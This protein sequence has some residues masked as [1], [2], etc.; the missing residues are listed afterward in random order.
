MRDLV[1]LVGSGLRHVGPTRPPGGP[2]DDALLAK[3]RG[4]DLTGY[5]DAHLRSALAAATTTGGP[6]DSLA[7]VHA[8]VNEA[9]GRR[10]GAWRILRTDPD[11]GPTATYQ[12][13]AR[14]VVE[15]AP[16]RTQIG[17]YTDEGFVDSPRF[18]ASLQ[19]LMD[20]MGLDPDERTVV[21]TIVY[22]FEKSK[23][24]Y[25]S[26][27]MLSSEFYR[28]VEALSPQGDLAFRVT[29]EQLMAGLLLYRG[30]IVEMNAGEGKTVAGAFPATMH[31]LM[32]RPVH[33]ITAN[34]YL[35]SRDAEWLAPVYES[36][37]LTVGAVLGHMSDEERRKTYQAQIV[38]GTLRE[39]GFDFLRDNLRLSPDEMV[40]R[41]L[42]VAIVDE[43]D[44]A[45][46]D[47]ARTPLIISGKPRVSRR[48]VRRAN[49]AVCELIGRQAELVSDLETKLRQSRPTAG[50]D[51]TL[52]ARLVLA[53]PES[54]ELVRWL[55]ADRALRRRVRVI[56]ASC[57][58]DG[59]APSIEAGLYYTVDPRRETVTLTDMGQALIE[60]HLGPTLDLSPSEPQLGRPEPEQD[61]MSLRERRR[62]ADKLSRQI[63]RRSNLMN[64]VHQ[65]LRAHLLL[66]R[67]VD[68]IVIDGE[69]VLIDAVTGR[70]RL[71]SMF[72][73]GLHTAL[74]AKEGLPL[75]P[76][77]E[78][79]AQVSIQGYAK[80]YR[81]LSG[82]TGTALSASDEFRRSYG[83][84]VQAVPPS[85]RFVRTDYPTRVF[86]KRRDKLAALLQEIRLCR[87]VGRPVLVGTVTV[88]QSSEISRMLHGHRI[89]HSLLN[90]VNSAGEAQIVRSAG[91]FGAVTVATNMAG[92]GTDIILEPGLNGRIVEGYVGLVEETLSNGAGDVA[93]ECSTRQEADVIEQSVRSAGGLSVARAKGG[94]RSEVVVRSERPLGKRG[95]RVTIEFGLGLY[96]VGTEM[97]ES[98]RINDQLRGRGGRQ[99][100]FGST[101]FILSLEDRALFLGSGSHPSGSREWRKDRAG[102][103]FLEGQRTERRLGERLALTE[104]EDELARLTTWEFNRV[105]ERQTMTYYRARGEV[106]D[107]G[108]LHGTCVD[109]ARDAA[110][111]LVERHLPEA[112]VASYASRFHALAEELELDYGTDLW[113][114]WGLGVE[115]LRHRVQD[116]VVAKL[117][118]TKA[119][120]RVPDFDEAEKLLLVQTADELWTDHLS[121]LQD[122]MVSAHLCGYSYRR[123]AAEYAFQCEEEYRRFTEAVIDTFIPR[124]VA[125]RQSPA[126]EPVLELVDDLQ[127]I[128][129]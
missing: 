76:E 113:P 37:G 122:M 43:A 6:D 3:I 67:D 9:V 80:R 63:F 8:I 52:L 117:E 5:S 106:I 115:G 30:S 24:A 15:A 7:E 55:A 12:Q 79:L 34:D 74:E 1:D 125:Y 58:A 114:L 126:R 96:V 10:L 127:E 109:F 87:R 42:D 33:V 50:E 94:G 123:A 17:Y 29:D 90:A 101:R 112:A 118:E 82:M 107:A 4:Y 61:R 124:L 23:V 31:A 39:F 70:R 48:A 46:V 121:R 116:L 75:R 83:L 85:N 99:G 81:H 54:G 95:A 47:E 73:H 49:S 120:C 84:H 77:S 45:L 68:Y 108:S 128:L 64:Q 60:R 78:V 66:R 98:G 27:I 26:Q 35:A 91:S 28:A 88:E 103:A 89:E 69:I 71:D 104:M 14:E 59:S 19:P 102:L 129:I 93:L 105:V 110:R 53:D 51:R 13:L 25:G 32:G 72:L 20:R 92:R 100:E 16:Y 111:R 57:D 119:R 38:Y 21:A 97:N 44:Q 11:P 65:M 62:A 36:L 86:E 2:S 41:E 56:V 22:V 40:Q 18:A